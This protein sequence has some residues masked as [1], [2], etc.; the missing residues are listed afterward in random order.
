MNPN[1]T[2]LESRNQSASD[3]TP[4]PLTGPSSVVS[5]GFQGIQPPSMLYVNVD[6]QL[7]VS[8]ATSQTAEVV[9]VNVRLLLPTG[10]IEDMQF[11]IR[12]ANTRT[13]LKQ[14]FGLAEGF[15]LSMSASA[16][17]ATT[18]GQ[19]FVRVALQRSAGGAGQPAFCLMADYVTTQAVP[20]YPNGRILSPTEGPGYVYG[21]SQSA[22]AVGVDQ[23]VTVPNNTR[24][25]V[26]AAWCQLTASAGVANRDV[27][28]VIGVGGTWTWQATSLAAV[29]A[30]QV[31]IF[32][33][34]AVT[35]YTELLG[36]FQI[37]PIPPDIVL[38]YSSFGSGGMSTV[39]TN[40]QAGDQWS[41]IRMLVEEW[42]DN[43]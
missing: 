14:S 17:V 36:T 32:S 41:A 43:I 10:R 35:P 19:T 33:I 1:Q 9:T 38:Q 24:W 27:T 28:I 15:L 25:R 4:A 39:T 13:V 8:A 12:P 16:A 3:V 22:P 2:L 26:R 37:L 29:T 20:G 31:V 7:I 23:A 18:R 11:Q 5:Y 34:G 40:L 6:D 30:S 21:F 42:L